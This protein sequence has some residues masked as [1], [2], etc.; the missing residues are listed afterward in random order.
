MFCQSSF[1]LRVEA[2]NHAKRDKVAEEPRGFGGTFHRVFVEDSTCVKLPPGLAAFFPGS[3]SHSGDN[4]VARIQLRLELLSGEYTHVE[5]QSYRDNDQKYAGNIIH[6]LYPGDLVLRDMGYTVLKVF[7]DIMGLGAFFLSRLRYGV[8]L[9]NPATG[10]QIDLCKTLQDARKKGI[11]E[12]DMKVLAGKEEQLPVRLVAIEAP[13]QVAQSRRRKAA[14]DRNKQANHSNEYM[15]LLGWTIFITNVGTETWKPR[16]LME[17][18][19]CRWHIEIVFKCWKSKFDFANLFDKKQ[20]MAPARVGITFYLLLIWLTL[21]FVRW[22]NFFLIAIYET[23]GKILSLLKFADFVK[24]HFDELMS[25][26]NHLEFL[27]FVARYFCHDKRTHPPG[28]MNKL[29]VLNL[30]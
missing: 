6:Q 4:A 27:N 26:N 29:Y 11:S 20:S 30:T 8:N 17:A 24:D 2:A 19:G 28:I 22:Y 12:L 1:G 21:F 16:Q 5:L 9:Y 25:T 18:Y 15:E 13:P 7:R 23:K 10:V 14:Q 3:Y